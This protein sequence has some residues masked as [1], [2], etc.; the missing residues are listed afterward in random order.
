MKIRK[1][2]VEGF[3]AYRS[4]EDG[5]FDFTI[6]NGQ[7]AN[8]VSLYAPNGFG[9]TS[10]YDAVEW[11][12]TNNIERFVRDATR[13]E[14]DNLSKAQNHGSRRQYILR[15]RYITESAPSQVTVVTDTFEKRKDVPKARVGSRD[16]LFKREDPDDGMEELQGLFLSQEAIDSFLKEERPD[17]RYS[18][19]ML[20]FGDSDETYRANLTAIKRELAIALRETR[21][22]EEALNNIISTPVNTKIFESANATIAAL[23]G[24]GESISSIS[25]NFDSDK[26][27]EIRNIITK[28]GHELANSLTDVSRAIETLDAALQDV[29]VLGATLDKRNAA[30]AAIATLQTRQSVLK[31]RAEMRAQL[32]AQM[33]ASERASK[34]ES[35]LVSLG[36]R[37]QSF[38]EMLR[39]IEDA[40]DTKT[41]AEERL[42]ELRAELSSVDSRIIQCKRLLSEFDSAANRL[43]ELQRNAAT[44]YQDVNAAQELLRQKRL[45]RDVLQARMQALTVK[46]ERS[47]EFLEKLSNLNISEAS[48]DDIDL[49]LLLDRGLSPI[50]LHSALLDKKVRQ[51]QLAETKAAV[52]NFQAQKDQLSTLIALGSELVSE[53]HLDKCPLCAHEHGSHDDLMRRILSHEVLSGLE[54]AALHNQDLAQRA[55]DEASDLVKRLINEWRKVKETAEL[56]ARQSL[57]GDEADLKSLSSDVQQLDIVIA[58]E[59]TQLEKLNEEVFRLPPEQLA[60]KLSADLLQLAAHRDRE[61]ADLNR[62]ETKSGQCQQEIKDRLQAIDEAQSRIDLSRQSSLYVDF[63]AFASTNAIDFEVIDSVLRV[64]IDDAR[65]RRAQSAVFLKAIQDDL[66]T[67]EAQ[68]KD[69]H[70]DDATGLAIEEETCAR[71]RLEAEAAIGTFASRIMPH[72]VYEE[73]S[74]VDQIAEAIRKE[75]NR[76]RQHLSMVTEVSRLFSLLGDQLKDVLPY[77]ASLT[78]KSELQTVETMRLRQEA[79]DASIDSEYQK[80][81]NRLHARINGFFYTK[82][83]N[84]IYRKI[85]PHPDFKEV[86]FVC[87][88]PDGEKPRLHVLVSD[89]D[90]DTIAPNLYFSAAQTNI[91]SLSIFLARALH[92]KVNGKEAGCIFIDDPIQSMDSINVLST[93]DLLRTLSKKF[94]RQIILSTHDRNFFELLRKKIPEREYGSKFIELESFGKVMRS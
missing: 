40:S 12:L 24:S 52:R 21:D 77:I 5:T 47:R 16:F 10:F 28:R 58:R 73:F 6:N 31:R 56:S 72:I 23:A 44:I 8:F 50:S 59:S 85:D 68:N 65:A 76:F 94:D 63:S 75:L 29:P 34:L 33:D 14:N 7:C 42:R 2:I 25:G 88:F 41:K 67:L 53:S 38:N 27:R 36:D 74:T 37:A 1:V 45:E 84:A 55:F 22:R 82:L 9:K 46:L 57:T 26:E 19:F 11:N 3:R 89:G 66:S 61:Q 90:S 51:G 60:E 30:V 69:L 49:T 43:I 70:S 17:A 15:N 64:Q 54:S 91:L 86:Q 80:V 35:T 83:I 78:A 4:V 48:A 13:L 92:V 79:L 62:S 71:T 32:S 81:I 93:I 39:K 87:E 18:R 20:H